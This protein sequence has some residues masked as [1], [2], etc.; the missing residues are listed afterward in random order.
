MQI[1]RA[2]FQDKE[3]YIENAYKD[4]LNNLQTAMSKYNRFTTTGDIDD[5][6]GITA[7]LDEAVLA[8]SDL[9]MAVNSE[10]PDISTVPAEVIE[11]LTSD[12][13]VPF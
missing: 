5:L 7:M 3:V 11:E 12:S 2:E 8:I 4:V 6:N 1:M 9:A 13:G 10:L